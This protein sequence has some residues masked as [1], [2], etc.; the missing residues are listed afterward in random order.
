MISADD[1]LD[2]LYDLR[3]SRMS[4]IIFEINQIRSRYLYKK[5][6][7]RHI[8]NRHDGAM[9]DILQFGVLMKMSI[10]CDLEDA[11][12]WNGSTQDLVKKLEKT[13]VYR[14]DGSHRDC[15][16]VPRFLNGLK[17]A[18]GMTLRLNLEEF[19]SRRCV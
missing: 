18:K 5:D 17:A 4:K 14:I 7:T 9:C 13:Q 10:D 3:A 11:A 6:A 19:P 2:R 16:W 12:T 15:S 8:C 1:F